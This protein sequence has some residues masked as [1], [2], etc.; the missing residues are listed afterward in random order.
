MNELPILD[1]DDSFQIRVETKEEKIQQYADYFLERD[2]WGD[3]PPIQVVYIDGKYMIADGIHRFNAAKRAGLEMIPCEVTPGDDW[4]L[5]EK[6]VEKNGVQGIDMGPKDWR[7]FRRLV[8]EK[9]CKGKI[10]PKSYAEIAKLCKC[11]AMTIGN[12][13]KEMETEGWKFPETAIGSDGKEYPTTKKKSV[14][15]NFITENPSGQTFCTNGCGTPIWEEMKDNPDCQYVEREGHWFCSEE[16]ADEWNQNRLS[17]EAE[18]LTG[19]SDK[20]PA[21]PSARVAT[22]PNPINY[23]TCPTIPV[24]TEVNDI[25]GDILEDFTDADEP[26]NVFRIEIP[27]DAN[28]EAIFEAIS[29][30]LEKFALTP[31]NININNIINKLI[32]KYNITTSVER[33][34]SNVKKSSKKPQEPLS[35]EE[36]TGFVWKLND[37]SDWELPKSELEKFKTLYPAV[38]VE[39]ELR[40]SIGWNMSYPNRRKTKSGMMGHLNT[41]LT[42]QQNKG[43]GQSGYGNANQGQRQNR[44]RYRDAGLSFEDVIY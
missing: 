14:I 43:G 37:G 33:K 1:L 20:L 18:R 25:S 26:E 30:V 40:N 13:R 4:T 11:S 36:K 16:C 34:I 9:I 7:K 15:K 29:D 3:F 35:E 28:E 6:S 5:L 32:N 8:M 17:D 31:S 22:K 24:K 19:I 44:S 39:Q 41:W 21:N 10:P 23:P 27:L 42:K 38:D 12:L 2:G